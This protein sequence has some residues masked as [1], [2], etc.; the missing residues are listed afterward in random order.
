MASFRELQEESYKT[1]VE[2]GWHDKE[3]EDNIPTKIALIHSEISEALEEYRNGRIDL[4]WSNDKPEG[5][6]AELADT[7]IRVMDLSGYLDIDLEDLIIQKQ[8][9]NRTRPYRHGGKAI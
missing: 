9:Y 1:A 8:A 2:K 7:V 6:G 4:W 3:V 5:F